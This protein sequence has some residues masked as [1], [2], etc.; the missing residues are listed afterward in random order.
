MAGVDRVAA[1]WPL[2]ILRVERF[3]LRQS[4]RSRLR[5]HCLLHAGQSTTTCSRKRRPINSEI[6]QAAVDTGEAKFGVVR[7]LW[8]REEAAKLTEMFPGERYELIEGDLIDKMGQKPP[9]A[10]VITALTALL[11]AAF[12]RRIRIQ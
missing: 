10:Y 12:P 9:H 5:R 11:G 6:M 1:R 3:L 7:K 2:P 4:P 8:T